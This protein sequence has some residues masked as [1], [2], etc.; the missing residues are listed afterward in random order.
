MLNPVGSTDGITWSSDNN[1]VAVNKSSGRIKANTTGTAYITAMTDSGKTA[2]TEVTVMV[3]MS[4][5]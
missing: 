1:A 2:T 4:L 3:L 5:S